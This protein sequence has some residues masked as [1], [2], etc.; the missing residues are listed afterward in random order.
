MENRASEPA[1]SPRVDGRALRTQ[2][3]RELLVGANLA[4]LEEGELRASAQ[5]VA[6]RAG[7]S[8]RTL[9]L[10]FADMEEL[11][12]ATALD[13]REGLERLGLLVSVVVPEG[14]VSPAPSDHHRGDIEDALVAAAATDKSTFR[15]GEADP[16]G[17]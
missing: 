13:D 17:S 12:A 5:R 6:E 9:F 3:T 14:P 10:H 11:F 7:V 15:L 4:L 2:R 1:T 8:V 16:T